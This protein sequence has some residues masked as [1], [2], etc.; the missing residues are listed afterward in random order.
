MTFKI[1][2]VTFSCQKKLK[3]EKH[4]CVNHK[5]ILIYFWEYVFKIESTSP[6]TQSVSVVTI[7]SMQKK[8]ASAYGIL[9]IEIPMSVEYISNGTFHIS[10]S[11]DTKRSEVI[12]IVSTT[13][14]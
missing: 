1:I 4:C 10:S 14:R 2:T 11:N 9:P 6:V 8:F 7:T 3:N 12:H 5:N 13:I